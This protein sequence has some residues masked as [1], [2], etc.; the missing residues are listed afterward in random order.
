MG[1][2]FKLQLLTH[3]PLFQAILPPNTKEHRFPDS[4]FILPKIQMDFYFPFTLLIFFLDTTTELMTIMCN[5]Y[6]MTLL[7]SVDLCLGDVFTWVYTPSLKILYFSIF[8]IIS[9]V[10]PK[11]EAR[12]IWA[13]L[14]TNKIH[15]CKIL[16]ENWIIQGSHVSGILKSKKVECWKSPILHRWP[17]QYFWFLIL[18]IM[19]IMPW[20]LKWTWELIVALVLSVLFSHLLDSL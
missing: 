1:W 18:N 3:K 5:M 10:F 19:D 2:R 8:Q 17:W 12:K 15:L 4:I 6:Q 20:Y 16:I 9:I 7:T 14:S 11:E 13:R